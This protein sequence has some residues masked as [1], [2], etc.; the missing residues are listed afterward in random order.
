MRRATPDTAFSQN[1][2][3]ITGRKRVISL[4]GTLDAT[5]RMRNAIAPF[6][7][8]T[9]PIPMVCAD[10]TAGNANTEG[11]SRTQVLNAVD[12]SQIRNGSTSTPPR[13]GTRQDRIGT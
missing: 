10:R 8:A 3:H 9:A 4:I 7:P 5:P 13:H 2:A 1:P 6:T 11:D 12:S